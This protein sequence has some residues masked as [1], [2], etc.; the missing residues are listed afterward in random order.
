M[1]NT[2]KLS[3]QY[4]LKTKNKK[5]VFFNVC[6][7]LLTITSALYSAEFEDRFKSDTIESGKWKKIGK[8]GFSIS[9]GILKVSGGYVTAGESGWD[10]YS[11]EFKARAP[12]NARQVQVWAGFRHHSRDFRYVVALRGGNNNHLYLARY[13]ATGNDK[14][15][16][17]AP[18]EF[19]PLPGEWYTIKVVAAGDKI[20]VYLNDEK[21]PR[22]VAEDKDTP[23]HTGGISLGGGYLPA[24][25]EWVKVK[26]VPEN[27]LRNVKEQE[28]LYK[29]T[30]NKE[31]KRRRQRKD[32]KPLYIPSL[33]KNRMVFSLDGDWLFAPDYQAGEKP[34]EVSYNDSGW[35]IMD[36]PNFWVPLQCWLQGETFGKDHFN[37]GQNDKFHLQ[38]K[39]R[40][41]GYTFDWEK[42]QSAWYRQYIDLPEGIK[43]KKVVV[44]FEAVA[45][46]STVYINGEKVTRHFGMFGPFEADITDYVH[47]GRNVLSLHV[48]RKQEDTNTKNVEINTNYAD[49][50][51]VVE[52]RESGEKPRQKQ[53][54]SDK[55][56]DMPQG[57]FRGDPGGI[58]RPV[59][60]VIT[61]KVKVEGFYFKPE[62]DSAEI[63]G[64][65]SN[66]SDNSEDVELYYQIKNCTSEEILCESKI[67]D[68]TLRANSEKQIEFS[69]PKVSPKLW[70]PGKPNLY[71]LTLSIK[72]D[73]ELL[74]S[75]SEKVG[76]RTFEVK[77][78]WLY[79]NG[80][81]LW[82]RGANHMPA[83]FMPNDKKLAE[84]FMQLALDNNVIATRTHCGPFT[85]G[86][87][88]AADRAGVMVSYEGTWP[89]LM[90]RGDEPPNEKSIQIWKSELAD[91]IKAN[92]NHPSIFLWTMNNEMK[93][94][95]LD[96]G[97]VLKK[98]AAIVS[99]AIEMV[100]NLDDTR[101][102]VAD[103]AYYRKHATDT[104]KYQNVIKPNNFDD[105]DID[106]AHAYYNWYQNSFFHLFD[107]QF[108]NHFYTPNRP[109]IS[110]ELST[111][112]PRS[113]DGLPTRFYLFVHQ[114]P[115]TLVG[116][117]AYEH[118]D[119]KYFQTRHAMMTK[120]LVEVFRRREHE[121]VS[122]IMP[123]AFV[124]WFYNASNANTATPMLTAKRL[125]T[126]Y[127]PVL[128]SVELLGR[129][130]FS[131][132]NIKADITLINDCRD[133]PVLPQ[134][135][136]VCKI[137]YRD[138]ILADKKINFSPVKY[139]STSTRT[140]K[141]KLPE[142]LPLPRINAELVVELKSDKERISVNRY[143][144]V[145]A[146]KDWAVNKKTAQK[147]K[148]YILE[149]DTT[150]DR[151]ASFYKIK[152]SRIQ[153]ISQLSGTKGVF[154][155]AQTEDIPPDYN[156]ITDFVSEGGKA[157][158]LNN[159][160][161]VKKI[162]PEI[163]RDYKDY[164]HEIVTMNIEESLVFEEIQ[165]LDMSWFRDGDNVPY[166]AT[167]RYS[168][169]RMN[170]D[171]KVMAET[172]EFHG[173][174]NSPLDY[175]KIGGSPLFEVSIDKGKILVSQMRCDSV[176]DDPVAARLIGNLLKNID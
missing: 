165:P 15:L 51:N 121:R 54:T 39:A 103:S 110:Q 1:H 74:D 62:L 146:E 87:L 99:D 8:G 40:C 128:T 142:T 114:T 50:W 155:L 156:K 158:L 124:T 71:R 58:W 131:G 12:E 135:E 3:G 97:K 42:T 145:L 5:A 167:G 174:L 88:D 104:G 148:Y 94:Y 46:I 140:L 127:Q 157:I 41:Y 122:G 93:F 101:P 63:Q 144:I 152:V 108:G 107:G 52:A 29:Q 147:H 72:Q 120:E 149:D 28:P 7:V 20:A 9:D 118:S 44:E 13:G 164:R 11:M 45:L 25:F 33:E 143:S 112:Y 170:P 81:P 161:A 111:G 98:K 47:K 2:A 80:K 53:H 21:T 27:H 163:V 69:T 23:F 126:A 19:S 68:I 173:Y 153:N 37:K 86:W 151:L 30:A 100:R 119:P 132:S 60:L 66:I 55:I 38:E 84:K 18:L 109:L 73:G 6:L 26:S 76:F 36:V 105:G 17:L 67:K 91:L 168:L 113:D 24:E 123:F 169:E 49:A 34:Y 172:L 102:V 133:F 171:V 64:R 78:D 85:Q 176:K 31:L 154:I 48:W 139:Y 116:N 117:K 57:F 59:K 106:D 141:I 22:I 32:Y 160:S 90:L 95:L 130:Y 159:G 138:K 96:E 134:T 125:K 162:L 65:Y 137:V 175:R 56:E 166:A 83:H 14:F 89:W 10:N 79:F 129:H 92:R 35:H 150:A 70:A 136:A 75:Y 61:D 115:Q 77:G 43:N 82:I 4:S 16:G